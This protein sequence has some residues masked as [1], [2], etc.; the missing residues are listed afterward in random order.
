[1]AWEGTDGLR[2]LLVLE[3]IHR[4]LEEY[5]GRGGYIALERGARE[6]RKWG[7]G[8]LMVSGAASGFR[9]ELR[10]NT[11]MEVQFRTRSPADLD[12]AKTR[13]GE[14]YGDVIPGL[15]TGEALVAH[16]KYNRGRP[17]TVR[18]RPPRHWVG[19]LP[20]KDLAVYREFAA[21]LDS[22]ERALA[23]LRGRGV[24]VGELELEVN[25]V[26]SKV[27]EGRFRMAEVYLESLRTSMERF[28]GKG[29]ARRRTARRK[30]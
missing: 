24:D 21:K 12:R 25:L 22:A 17:V 19:R 29:A 20:A 23:G 16:P 7:V 28:E 15:E 26:R 3:E 14:E 11:L 1:M 2:L 10:S 27:V 9:E 5:G 18:F 6:F 30:K 4:L 8:M 13:F